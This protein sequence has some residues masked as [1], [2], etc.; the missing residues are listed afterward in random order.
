MI[1]AFDAALLI[2]CNGSADGCS[3]GGG[4]RWGTERFSPSSSEKIRTG[5]W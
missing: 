3:R 2:D 5:G 4:R 1:F